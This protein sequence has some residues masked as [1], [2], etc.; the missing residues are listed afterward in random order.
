MDNGYEEYKNKIGTRIAGI[1]GDSL[2]QLA[3]TQE[4]AEE[5]GA[6][7]LENID[8]A[9]TNSELLEF[10]TNLSVKWPIFNSILTSNDQAPPVT[11]IQSQQNTTSEMVQKAEDLIKENKIDEALQVTKEAENITQNP[12]VGTGG[13]V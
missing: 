6:Y 9:K 13:V 7:V 10:V 4:Q 11:P 12:S 3:I 1:I 8:K 5:I 2:S